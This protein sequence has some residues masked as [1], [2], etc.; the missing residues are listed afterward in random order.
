MKKPYETALI[1]KTIKNFKSL[2]S[3][4]LGF[5]LDCLWLLEGA[6]QSR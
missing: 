1:F 3:L 6:C 4:V 5:L 2:S